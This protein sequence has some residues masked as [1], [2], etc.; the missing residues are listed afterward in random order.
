MRQVSR[1]RPAS[2]ARGATPT[3]SLPA[4]PDLNPS[5]NP[6]PNP[7]TRRNPDLF[8]S[9]DESDP[10]ECDADG[11]LPRGKRCHLAEFF[12]TDR[13]EHDRMDTDRL[14]VSDFKEPPSDDEG[15]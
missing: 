10:D 13:D 8:S 3:S 12:D 11:R 1:C 9:G 5:P 2:R 6:Y 4:N 14:G 15:L 7:G